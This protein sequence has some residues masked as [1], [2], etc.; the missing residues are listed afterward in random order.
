MEKK[1]KPAKIRRYLEPFIEQ[2]AL[3]RNKMA[4][5]SGPRQCGKTTMAKQLAG[6]SGMYLNWDS[7]ASRALW[8]KSHKDFASKI[9]DDQKEILVL[10]EFHKNPKWKNQLKGFYDFYG[11]DIKIVLTGSAK[12][13]TYKKGSDS[14]LGRFLHF[15]I[16]PFTLTELEKSS[17]NSF[18]HFIQFIKHPDDDHFPL[19]TTST[20]DT[21]FK[22]GGFPEPF[23]AQSDQI[24]RIWSKNR[25]ELL[26]RQDLKELSQVI[27]IG[28]VEILSTFLPDKIGSPLSVQS[29]KEDLDV[30]HTTLSR[31]LNALSLV[32]YHFSIKPYSKSIT[33]SLKKEPKVY[34]YDWSTI[35][36][37][38]SRFENMVACHLLKLIDFF[39]DTGVADME[40][41]YLRNKEKFEVDFLV[42]LNKKPFFTLEAKLNDDK[43][44]TKHLVFTKQLKIPH[45]QVTKKA[46][47]LK[48]Y[49]LLGIKVHSYVISFE[50]FFINGV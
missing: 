29:L 27:Q 37:P 25:L 46:G 31:W 10:D 4:F 22:F 12:L 21:L 35:Q 16:H 33:R 1:P 8:T 20:L 42:T 14:L 15:N 36:N 45:F 7:L 28:Q 5:F 40:L 17:P 3:E 32:Y 43:I 41:F 9:I 26:I 18:E 19:K 2:L 13:N 48:K 6:S 11:D 34:L 23:L 44:D 49:D 47:L 38:G 39:N 30:A 24:Q 50:K